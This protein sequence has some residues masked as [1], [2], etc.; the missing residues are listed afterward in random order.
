MRSGLVEIA[1]EKVYNVDTRDNDATQAEQDELFREIMRHEHLSDPAD[2]PVFTTDKAFLRSNGVLSDREIRVGLELGHIVCDP[3]PRSINGSSV[4][5]TIGKQFYAAGEPHTTDTI[6]TPYDYEDTLRYYGIKDPETDFLTA[7]PWGAVLKKVKKQMGQRALARYENEEQLS[8]IPAEHP[9]IL[10]RPGERILAHTNEFIGILPPG[11]TSMQARSTT[12]RIGLS[13]C[14]CAGWGDPGYINRWTME[15][16]NLNEKEFLP[17]PVGF[18]LA[19]IIFSM[20]GSVGTEYAQASGNYQA[21]NVVD[22]S[23]AHG[24]KQQRQ[25][26]LRATKS[27]WHPSNMLPRAYKN[28]IL[29][30]EPVEGLQTGIA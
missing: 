19:Q 13:A 23:Y 15:I 1:G 4:D 14:Y 10:L 12:G 17:V 22:L 5:V 6:F 21:Q 20:T 26:T 30:L 25:E 16:H 29:P 8:R 7:E 2:K 9:M 3:Y 18:R 28:E 11:T 27:Q 24:L